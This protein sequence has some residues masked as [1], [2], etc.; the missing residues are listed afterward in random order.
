SMAAPRVTD[1]SVKPYPAA[2]IASNELA[3]SDPFQDVNHPFHLGNRVVC[4]GTQ[5][6]ATFAHRADHPCGLECPIRHIDPFRGH[7]E[8]TRAVGTPWRHQPYAGSFGPLEYRR[9]QCLQVVGDAL[10]A[11]LV[12]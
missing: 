7:T 8:D 4:V 9:V 3:I 1:G 10:D 5:S 2:S 12:Q 6:N 11:E